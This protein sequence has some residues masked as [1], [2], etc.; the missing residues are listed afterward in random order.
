[1]ADVM[2]MLGN[3]PKSALERIFAALS[4]L[5]E[6]QYE[7][8]D[9]P[10]R[11][12]DVE[13]QVGDE[14]IMAP[15]PQAMHPRRER[16]GGL[17]RFGK[18]T[19]G[20]LPEMVRGALVGVSNPVPGDTAAQIFGTMRNVQG[21]RTNRE[22][23]AMQMQDR[24]MDRQQQQFQWH[25]Q[26]RKDAEGSELHAAQIDNYKAQAE[27]R[28]AAANR[29]PVTKD[30]VAKAKAA[31]QALREAGITP[32]EEDIRVAYQLQG[33]PYA[34]RTMQAKLSNA[35]SDY[36]RG[37]DSA[38]LQEQ[39]PTI[40][41]YVQGLRIM[42]EDFQK[43][44]ARG[45]AEGKAEG[46]PLT[47]KTLTTDKG[48]VNQTL[49]RH[50]PSGKTLGVNTT[51]YVQEPTA[52]TGTIA[53]PPQRK[54]SQPRAERPPN[55]QRVVLEDG[56]IGSFNPRTGQVTRNTTEKAKPSGN[57]ITSEQ[58]APFLG[59]GATPPPQGGPAKEEWVRDANGKLVKKQ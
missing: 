42:A 28:R 20:I 56:T 9:R 38:R 39:Y 35:A 45:N 33:M 46:T 5:S 30:P 59:R 26:A 4:G 24:A 21:D 1:M 49:Q 10:V 22:N 18:F 57:V 47:T 29:Q 31:L 51:E 14:K 27:Q 6:A 12:P 16:T 41:E 48:F 17:S 23:R 8:E 34:A 43:A 11:N 53:K 40:E 13:M 2:R 15:P 50:L 44:E 54:A 55:L 19:K 58:L 7:H 37:P 32:S 36:Y 52:A 25:R 3:A